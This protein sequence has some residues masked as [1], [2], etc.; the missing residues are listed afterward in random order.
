MKLLNFDA[1]RYNGH[2]HVFQ[3]FKKKNNSADNLVTELED[4]SNSFPSVCP[5]MLK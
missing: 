3:S 1:E 2:P 5:E 4:N